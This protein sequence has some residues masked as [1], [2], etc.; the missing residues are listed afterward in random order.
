MT[1]PQRKRSRKTGKRQYNK[2]FHLVC[3]G[4][5]TEPEYF[6]WLKQLVN[7]N[8][9]NLKIIPKKPGRSSPPDLIEQSR[10][11][12]TAYKKGDMIWIVM[13]HDEWTDGQFQQI[14]K[15]E[16]EHERNHVAVSNPKFEYWILLHDE[17]DP[18]SLS[19]NECSRKYREF[20]S[21]KKGI[22]PTKLSPASV[23]LAADRARQKHESNFDPCRIQHFVFLPRTCGSTLYLLIDELRNTF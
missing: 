4:S 16:N 13:D 7:K 22:K 12:D 8:E 1:R 9:I 14:H 10:K 3:E 11:I 2:I 5:K 23:L 20:M 19:S 18:G 15:W 17:Q 21:S 6:N